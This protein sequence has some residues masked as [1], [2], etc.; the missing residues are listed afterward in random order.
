MKITE[1]KVK[2]KR[3]INEAGGNGRIVKKQ[4]VYVANRPV[5]VIDSGKR[6]AHFFVDMMIIK[7]IWY[8]LDF[9][10]SFFIPKD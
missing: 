6:F 8:C 5:N 9:M 7:V 10:S 3:I 4:I 1:I 2:R